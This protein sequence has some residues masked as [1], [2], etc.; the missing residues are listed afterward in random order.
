MVADLGPMVRPSTT[1]GRR[2]G[3]TTTA[4]VGEALGPMVR[5]TAPGALAA[6]RPR[7]LRTLAAG[8]W[9]QGAAAT[10]GAPVR[11]GARRRPG[12]RQRRPGTR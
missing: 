7:A 3:P 4:A 10:R 12:V 1:I 2:S 6:V 5:P 8:G 9:S 11:P